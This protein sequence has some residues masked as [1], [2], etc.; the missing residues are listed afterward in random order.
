[1]LTLRPVWLPVAGLLIA[2]G[3]TV[4][5]W[6]AFQITHPSHSN[7][8]DTVLRNSPVAAVSKL[9]ELFADL[10]SLDENPQGYD[11]WMQRAVQ[12]ASQ[13]SIDDA[14][15][16]LNRLLEFVPDDTLALR[17]L[18]QLN[19]GCG[20]RL[21]AV[22]HLRHL[23]KLGHA[24]ERELT[25][26]AMNGDDL[27][28][29]DRVLMLRKCCPGDL[30]LILAHAEHLRLRHRLPEAREVLNG[31]IQQRPGLTEMLVM[32][33]RVADHIGADLLQA[34]FEAE[35]TA[36]TWTLR[37]VHADFGSTTEFF[38]RLDLGTVSA[39][40]AV[41]M[42]PSSAER[43]HALA[44]LL[45]H[46]GDRES[47]EFY[48]QRFRQLTELRE[49]CRVRA[50][51]RTPKAQRCV[52]LL[53]DLDRDSEATA[54]CRTELR[55]DGDSSWAADLLG[56]TKG[57]SE[58]APHDASRHGQSG[59]VGSEPEDDSTKEFPDS[60]I[61]RFDHD[62]NIH[63]EPASETGARR[64]ALCM[65]DVAAEVGLEFEFL[66]GTD[67][68]HTGRRMHEFTGGGVGVLDLDADTWPDLFFTQG[69]EQLTGVYREPGRTSSSCDQLFRNR[70][71]RQFVNVSQITGITE[72]M[73]GQG[74]AVGDVNNDGFDDVYT[75]NIGTNIL[76]LNQGDGTFVS[77]QPT[78]QSAVWT[79]SAAV[80]DLN[81]D[82]IPDL[83]DVNYVGGNNVFTQICNH[84]GRPRIC[85]PTDFPGEQDCLPIGN[86]DGTFRPVGRAAEFILPDGRGMGIVA[87]DLL[88]NGTVQVLVA[89]DES[90]NFFF[91]ISDDWQLTNTAV[92]R[93][94]A[95]GRNG[96]GQGSMGIAVTDWHGSLHNG[97]SLFVTNYFGESNCLHVQTSDGFF[98]DMIAGSGLNIP[99]RSMLGFGTQF[100]DADGDGDDDL[101]VANGHVDDFEYMGIP[102]RMRPQLFENTAGEFQETGPSTGPYFAA[103]ALG[104]AVARLDW[105]RD[106]RMDLC[107]TH[108]DRPV[109]LLENRSPQEFGS[110][111]IRYTGIR[112][113]R[114]G[115]GTLLTLSHLGSTLTD[116]ESVVHTVT[117]PIL[118][119]DGYECSN[120]RVQNF[121]LP[122]GVVRLR[123]SD[124]A[125][126][127]R[128]VLTLSEAAQ[129]Q[130]VEGRQGVWR[131]PR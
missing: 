75:A 6:S 80:A 101:F 11:A 22:G 97:S 123:I 57:R 129:L 102:F 9:A 79:I 38:D 34:L 69:T 110:V 46:A 23:V 47:A 12:S 54:W 41:Q 3:V 90:A 45:A 28:G 14:I 100:L 89:N 119:G 106:G 93:G 105:N 39:L 16:V 60:L 24:S 59:N 73:F 71:G 30:R 88:K 20:L 1:M 48:L 37:S 116:A 65:G 43:N 29:F 44:T 62:R 98:P 40:R 109:A 35:D 17:R 31:A 120:E 96:T 95:Y 115:V 91:E 83:Y 8:R 42:N 32:R 25:T 107:V 108:L 121:V 33:I 111:T 114:D 67:S 2:A 49:L 50:V 51:F 127:S 21:R 74:I 70:R 18:A 118:A 92:M 82:G 124:G 125:T 87:G 104:R 64:T 56:R 66:C 52:Q 81:R 86:G 72:N 27:W 63:P 113:S 117:R 128:V 126:E 84:G 10:P 15:A 122:T 99:G 103:G 58:S 19:A 13:G 26:L 5:I 94:L 61:I 77:L 68:E 55:V 7:R 78:P 85:G 131:I 76:W 130:I 112:Q 53:L 36:D 4:S